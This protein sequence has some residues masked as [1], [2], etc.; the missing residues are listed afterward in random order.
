M[1][2]LAL[3]PCS[4]RRDLR[5]LMLKFRWSWCQHMWLKALSL[6]PIVMHEVCY[7]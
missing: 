5:K 6:Y 7:L 3:L 1:T 4:V 2:A